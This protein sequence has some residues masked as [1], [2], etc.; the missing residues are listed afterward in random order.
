MRR[1]KKKL[2]QK[3]FALFNQRFLHERFYFVL[4]KSPKAK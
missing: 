4:L 2:V 1:K 3:R